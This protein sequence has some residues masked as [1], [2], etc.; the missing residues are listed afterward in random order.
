MAERH[1][2][3]LKHR[4]RQNAGG[5]P[6]LSIRTS[7]APRTACLQPVLVRLALS[8]LPLAG[9][10]SSV[11]WLQV[12]NKCDMSDSVRQVPDSCYPTLTVSCAHPMHL[13]SLG[14]AGTHWV[15]LALSL[16]SAISLAHWLTGSPQ[17]CMLLARTG[18]Q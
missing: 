5:S 6:A 16:T 2:T 7:A 4:S 15:S 13:P 12:G 8:A 14:V 9:T 11:G 10:L 18:S 17:L 1:R 3:T